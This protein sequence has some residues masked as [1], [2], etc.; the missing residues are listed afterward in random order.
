MI[1]KD[2]GHSVANLLPVSDLATS[3]IL[4]GP[5]LAA[6]QIS[7]RY[8]NPRPRHYYTVFQKNFTLFTFTR[9]L[10]DVGRFS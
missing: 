5:E 7:T 4:K 3:D 9:T 8:L 10:S 2:G 1:L 6:Y